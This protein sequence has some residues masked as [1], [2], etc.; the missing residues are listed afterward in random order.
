VDLDT[1]AIEGELCGPFDEA[2]QEG[3]QYDIQTGGHGW[4]GLEAQA[5]NEEDVIC[6]AYTSGTTAR[7][8]GVEYTHRGVY[9]AALGNVIE[10][11][12]NLPDGR[13]HYLWTLPMFHAIG[14][15]QLQLLDS[16]R[17]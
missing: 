7:P 9:L 10:S 17:I 4:A 16:N 5:A 11:G 6:L 2:V 15:Y 1:D 14:E 13:C 12:L 8:K 3:L